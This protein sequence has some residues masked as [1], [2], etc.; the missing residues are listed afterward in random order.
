MPD[1]SF[2]LRRPARVPGLLAC[3]LALAG[4][5]QSID[6]AIADVTRADRQVQ[7]DR[8]G[9]RFTFRDPA[10]RPPEG[11]PASLALPDSFP[12][13]VYLPGRYRVLDVAMEDGLQKLRLNA[14]GP[15][16]R[17]FD[18]ARGTMQQRGWR[19]VMAVQHGDS[20]RVLAFAKPRRT[21]VLLFRDAADGEVRID[22]Q[23]RPQLQ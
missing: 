7:V 20:S 23:L 21:A 13:D 14:R 1:L 18:E 15:A 10:T 19:P 4:C 12:A 6:N 2:P 11:E 8:N 5:S 9:D 22:L 3:V 17:L 16:T